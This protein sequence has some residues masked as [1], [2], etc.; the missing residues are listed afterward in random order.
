MKS[1]KDLRKRAA[2][3]LR[4]RPQIYS[5]SEAR[6]NFA[7]TLETVRVENAIIGFDRYGWPMAA[8]VPVE[9]VFLLAGRG[10]A[11]DR[12][13]REAIEEAAA[14]FVQNLPGREAETPPRRPRA[15]KAAPK[16]KA[17]RRKRK[18]VGKG[19]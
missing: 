11:V 6:K 13:K 7:E 15:A 10:Q 4:K 14:V 2:G 19:V 18:T 5:T 9:A 16:K 17:A 3:R 12:R 1:V 8:L